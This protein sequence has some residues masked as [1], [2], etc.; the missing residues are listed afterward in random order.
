[1]SK[2]KYLFLDVDGTLT[3][4]KIYISEHGEAFKAF[5]VKDGCGLKD[6]LPKYDIVPVIITARNS[7]ILVNRCEELGID[8]LFQGERNKLEKINSI[9]AQYGIEKNSDG[10][11]DEAAYIGD[12]ILDIPGMKV[13]SVRGCPADAVDEVKEI[14]NFVSDKDA[15][16]G[17]VRAFIDYIVKC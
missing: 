1:M 15:G 3:D 16:E 7:K 12:D 2:I 8:M 10:V 13:C 14:C 9:M 4:G 6:I 17:A 5:N 11:Y